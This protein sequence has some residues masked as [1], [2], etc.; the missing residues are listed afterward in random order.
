MLYAHWKTPAGT[1]VTIPRQNTGMKLTV[2][3]TG[4]NVNVRSGPETYYECLYQAPKGEQ[5]EI[6]L[7]VKR[8][9]LYWGRSGDKW[10]ALMYTDYDTAK[11]KVLPMWGK[12]TSNTL[13]VRT[14]AGTGN[15]LVDGAAKSK[16]D[17]ILITDWKTDETVMWGKIEEG[18]VSLEYVT[19][20]G[21]NSPDQTVKSIEIH[22]NPDKLNYVHKVDALDVTGGKLLVTYADNSSSFVDIT[23]GMVSGFDNTKVGTNKVTVTY[24][25][26]TTTFDVQIVKAKVVFKMDNGSVIS[27]TEYLF[28]DTVTVPANP[29]KPA[30]SNGYYVFMGW[31]REVSATCNGNAEYIAVF[32]QRELVGDTNKDGK[33]NDRDVLYLLDHVLFPNT[34]PVNGSTDMNGDGKTND[35][36]VLY[37]LDHVLFPDLY[38]LAQ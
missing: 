13:N 38:P 29:T 1:P 6:D 18:W 24:E 5:L 9:T 37:L 34:Y 16:G 19:F 31:G 30:D 23:P 12:V 11:G 15:A 32:Q 3:V 7:V 17:L 2:T 35:R 4:N 14:G 33:I 36:D 20:D 25:G 22:K 8:G 21:V 26:K 28:G 27:E 10:I